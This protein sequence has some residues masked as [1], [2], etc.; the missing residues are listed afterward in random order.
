MGITFRSFWHCYT[1][2][3]TAT[4]YL[5]LDE[6]RVWTWRNGF[7]PQLHLNRWIWIKNLVNFFY[8]IH[9]RRIMQQ[10]QKIFNSSDLY[11]FGELLASV[12]IEKLGLFK[13]NLTELKIKKILKNASKLAIIFLAASSR[14]LKSAGQ[15]NW[16]YSHMQSIKWV[17]F[18]FD[19]ITRKLLWKY[20]KI[21]QSN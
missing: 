3:P 2:K 13:C 18:S 12:Y 4:I 19:I 20:C 8:E 21:L 14:H 10:L 7:L 16:S 1:R 17:I 11:V 15:K 6:K 5:Q 9:L